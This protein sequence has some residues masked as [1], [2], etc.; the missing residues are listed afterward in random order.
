VIVIGLCAKNTPHGNEQDDDELLRLR[1]LLG[2]ALGRAK[3]TVMVGYKPDEESDLIKYF[4]PGTFSE[5]EL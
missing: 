2:M 4:K 5:V 1:R 3:K